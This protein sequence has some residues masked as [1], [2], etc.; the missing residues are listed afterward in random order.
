M[1]LT[2]HPATGTSTEHRRTAARVT[3]PSSVPLEMLVEAWLSEGVITTGQAHQILSRAQ[4][5]AVDVRATTPPPA[6]ARPEVSSFVVEGLG[7]LG[8][9]I[10]LVSAFLIASTFWGDLNTAARL[11]VM[12]GAS[13]GLLGAGTA[14]PA[15][16]GGVGERL[17]TVL[18]VLSV[19]AFAGFIT[20]LGDEQLDL[21]G[22]DVRPMAAGGAAALAAVLWGL[23]HRLA[24][25]A[26]TMVAVMVTA[27]TVIDRYTDAPDL[28]GLGVWAVGVVWLLLGWGGVLPPRRAV[29]AVGSTAAILGGMTTAGSDVGAGLSVA[30]ALGVVAGAVVF[31]DLL[32]L[33]IGAVGAMLSLPPAMTVWFP[34]TRA[35]PYVLLAVGVLLVVTAIWIARRRPAAGPR[36]ATRDYATGT[37][38][39][40]VVASTL[41]TVAVVALVIADPA[42]W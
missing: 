15:R 18:W 36:T 24:Q 17:H 6:L 14:V 33:A 38:V 27:A 20:L 23:R 7:Y 11:T 5:Q 37:A 3:Q 31:R 25:Q 26:T 13:L 19:P 21:G 40:A 2:L 4:T 10:I 29:V 42:W 16:L 8:G 28:P 35:A 34:D 22:Q 32:L 30:T 9:V 12:G 39:P 41:I 1:R